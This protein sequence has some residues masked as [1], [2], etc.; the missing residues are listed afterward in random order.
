MKKKEY[1]KP[2]LYSAGGL[3][4]DKNVTKGVASQNWIVENPISAGKEEQHQ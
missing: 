1:I 3:L 2:I 4:N